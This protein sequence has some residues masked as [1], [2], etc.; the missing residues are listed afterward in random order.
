LASSSARR[1]SADGPEVGWV[2]PSEFDQQSVAERIIGSEHEA[3][4]GGADGGA[5]VA[6]PLVGQDQVVEHPH[7]DLMS[8]PWTQEIPCNACLDSSA[9]GEGIEQQ[10]RIGTE[11]AD[12]EV[13]RQPDAGER[14]PCSTSNLDVHHRQQNRQ[15]A[16][17]TEHDVKHRVGVVVPF[18][19]ALEPV[20]GAQ[21]LRASERHH[22]HDRVR[23]AGQLGKG[24]TAPTHEHFGA[25]SLAHEKPRSRRVVTRDSRPRR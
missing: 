20:C 1:R 13:A 22:V 25:P 7:R 17:P 21:Q 4:A 10:R 11:V 8:S 23:L 3:Q 14:D 9:T 16:A 5:E 6:P 12:H 19:V 24:T 2:G 15:A 18:P